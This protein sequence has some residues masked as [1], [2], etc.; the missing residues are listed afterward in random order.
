MVPQFLHRAVVEQP[1]SRQD[2]C[3]SSVHSCCCSVSFSWRGKDSQEPS[4]SGSSRTCWRWAAANGKSSSHQVVGCF[5]ITPHYFSDN[6]VFTWIRW[7]I[8]KHQMV[9]FRDFGHFK[10]IS[11]LHCFCSSE[12]V[13]GSKTSLHFIDMIWVLM[14]SQVSFSCSYLMAWNV[15]L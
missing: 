7:S 11:S 13:L 4:P 14:L 6:L 8:K 2:V 9:S 12:F 5:I 1:L 3:V 15:W 10:T